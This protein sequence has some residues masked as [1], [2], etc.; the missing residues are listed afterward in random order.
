MYYFYI[1]FSKT[2]NGYYYGSTS[3][4]K[5][6]VSEHQLGKVQSTSYRRP[7]KIVYYE[8]YQT[9]SGAR[10]R[11]QQVKRSSSIRAGLHKRINS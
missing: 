7:L 3:N 4:L 1:L 6:R 10:E 11:E 9:V 2:D 5:K 8:A